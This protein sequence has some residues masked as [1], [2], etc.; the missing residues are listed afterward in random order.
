MWFDTCSLRDSA[1]A[2]CAIYE[3]R[4]TTCLDLNN[5]TSMVRNPALDKNWEQS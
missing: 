1:R 4:A 3:K 2:T 5:N